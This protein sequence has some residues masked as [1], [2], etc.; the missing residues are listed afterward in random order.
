MAQKVAIAKARSSEVRVA[1][2]M[3][4][5]LVAA[6]FYVGRMVEEETLL[7]GGGGGRRGGGGG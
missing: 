5:S 6:I 7:S 3:D 2:G 4:A 1:P